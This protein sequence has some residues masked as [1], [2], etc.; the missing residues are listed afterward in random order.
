M[1]DGKQGEIMIIAT[2]LAGLLLFS[3]VVCL[4]GD[5]V[6]VKKTKV[7]KKHREQFKQ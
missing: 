4:Q 3:S 5:N 1:V 7:I 6:E 2:I